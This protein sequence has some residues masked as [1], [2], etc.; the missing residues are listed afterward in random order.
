MNFTSFVFWGSFA[1][2]CR[3]PFGD[4]PLKDGSTCTVDPETLMVPDLWDQGSVIS[5]NFSDSLL[6][7]EHLTLIMNDW[8]VPE[9]RDEGCLCLSLQAC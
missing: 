9:F 3:A 4:R 5:A 6:V 8:L 2:F 1:G 7:T